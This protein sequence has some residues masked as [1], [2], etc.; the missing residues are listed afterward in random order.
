LYRDGDASYGSRM[1]A[2]A[3]AMGALLRLLDPVACAVT[4]P[5]EAALARLTSVESHV[6]P[7]DLATADPKS[8]V[9]IGLEDELGRLDW[10]GARPNGPIELRA[11]LAK[12]ESRT[13]KRGSTARVVVSVAALESSGK[14]L[15]QVQGR[16]AA[17]D[18]PGDRAELE[19]AVLE[20]AARRAASAIPEA[21]RRAAALR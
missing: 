5:V 10:R 2:T 16:A 11:V 9:R 15:G 6:A 4:A 3:I 1:L 13:T 12:A 19:Q 14:L 17:E 20:A 8:A 7:R 18:E 21:V